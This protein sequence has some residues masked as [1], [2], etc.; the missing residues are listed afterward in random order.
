MQIT[1][2]FQTMLIVALGVGQ[3]GGVGPGRGRA[4][5]S[6]VGGTVH[7]G[8]STHTRTVRRRILIEGVMKLQL[9]Y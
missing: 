8:Y 4:G 1:L 2:L 6:L 3:L 9:Q 5:C 7:V